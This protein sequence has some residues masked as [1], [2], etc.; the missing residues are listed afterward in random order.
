TGLKEFYER[1]KNNYVWGERI[2]ATIYTLKKPS[3]TQKLINFIKSGLGDQDLL[4]EMNSDTAKVL[5]LE[6]SKFS[7]KDNKYTDQVQWVKGISP[8]LKAD[9]N[10]STVVVVNIKAIL[11]PE[12]KSLNEAKGLITADYQNYLEKIWIQFLHQKFPVVINK[13]VLAKIK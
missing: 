9:S 6:S 12:G 5:T 1:N 3:L 2:D 8:V 7:I 4:K 10:S 13:E 11:K